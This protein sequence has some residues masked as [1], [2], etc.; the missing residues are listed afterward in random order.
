M[1]PQHCRSC[2]WFEPIP[3]RPSLIGT[4]QFPL[5][6]WLNVWVGWS[7]NGY[8]ARVIERGYEE[9]STYEEAPR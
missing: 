5:P 7:K 4:C 1:S 8:T 6:Q 2:K 9:C 3:N